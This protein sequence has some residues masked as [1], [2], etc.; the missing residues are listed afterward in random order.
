MPYVIV[1]AADGPTGQRLFNVA[2]PAKLFRKL[3]RAMP[4]TVSW[5]PVSQWWFTDEL[6]FLVSLPG[7]F[8]L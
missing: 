7:T 5:L 6:A 1:K 2:V 3:V 4:G 8:R